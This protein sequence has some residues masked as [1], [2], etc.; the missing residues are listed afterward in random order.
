MIYLKDPNGD[1]DAT[2]P[3]QEARTTIYRTT[4]LTTLDEAVQ[5]KYRDSGGSQAHRLK[6]ADATACWSSGPHPAR[7]QAGVRF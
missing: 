7:Q 6:L 3:A 1:A 2:E 4:A 5:E